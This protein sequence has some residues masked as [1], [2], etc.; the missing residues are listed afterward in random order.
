M[1]CRVAQVAGRHAVCLEFGEHRQD[2][3]VGPGQ[4]RFLSP[5]FRWASSR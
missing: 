4:A 1:V 3:V 5:R 2:L